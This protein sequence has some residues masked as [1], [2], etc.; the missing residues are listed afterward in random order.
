MSKSQEL[1]ALFSRIPRR[2]T[3]DNVKEMQSIL[4]EYEEVLREL[5][6]DPAYEAGVAPFFDELESTRETI[7]NA[8]LNKH[9]KPTKD[10]LFD[11][12]SGALK[13]TM[14]ALM[15]MLG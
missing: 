8:S 2:H 5:E 12:G 6:S 7:K 4:D 1:A 9:S 11:E 10:K 3:A 14:E 15:K 13:E